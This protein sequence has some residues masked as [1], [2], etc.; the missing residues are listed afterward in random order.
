M[1]GEGFGFRLSLYGSR[2]IESRETAA[3]KP[4]LL[5]LL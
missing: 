2:Q 1:K 4:I 5:Q 3:Y